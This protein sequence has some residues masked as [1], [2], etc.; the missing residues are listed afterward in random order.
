MQTQNISDP[1]SISITQVRKDI[2]ILV[3][4]LNKQ[5]EV[6]ILKGRKILFKA[7]DPNFEA[8]RQARIK[9]AVEGIR[10]FA[11]RHKPKPGEKP[12]SQWLIEE[13]DKMRSPKYYE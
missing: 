6:N 11:K 1:H 10:E 2:D 3:N 8:K 7:I 9:K 12:L 13:R 5:G 4:L